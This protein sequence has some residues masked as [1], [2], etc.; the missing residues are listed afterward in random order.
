MCSKT[1]T[2]RLKYRV[3][4]YHII[5]NLCMLAEISI[6]KHFRVINDIDINSSN[7]HLLLLLF[8]QKKSFHLELR[9]NSSMKNINLNWKGMPF[10]WAV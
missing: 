9:T 5:L 6:L 10:Y 1:W 8:L 7:R 2:N 3:D 4:S